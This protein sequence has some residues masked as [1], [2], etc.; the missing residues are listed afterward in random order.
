MIVRIEAHKS[1]SIATTR[2][3][4]AGGCGRYT[5]RTGSAPQREYWPLRSILNSLGIA[6]LID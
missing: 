2:P 1:K 3:I 5:A 6:F 4:Q